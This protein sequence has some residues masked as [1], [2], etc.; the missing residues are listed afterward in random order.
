MALKTFK[1]YTKS[2]RATVLINREN[3]W[4]GKPLKSLTY[5][6]NSTG[7]RNNAGRMG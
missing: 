6:K 1:P 3:L 4:K 5:G 2:R 7:G